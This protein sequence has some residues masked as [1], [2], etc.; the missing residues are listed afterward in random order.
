MLILILYFILILLLLSLLF[1]DNFIQ[2]ILVL[3]FI[4]VCC[5][6]LYTRTHAID[7]AF[8]EAAIGAGISTALTLIIVHLTKSYKP[9]YY[10]KKS[11]KKFIRLLKISAKT[12]IF[13]ILATIF[14]YSISYIPLFGQIGNPVHNELS[15][16]YIQNSY[17]KFDIPNI[18]TMILGSFRGF[19]TMGETIVVFLAAL[20]VYLVLKSPFY[21]VEEQEIL[22]KEEEDEISSNYSDFAF[23]SHIILPDIELIKRTS[24]NEAIKSDIVL[25][26]TLFLLIPIIFIFGS[27]VQFYGDYGPGGGFQ[28]GVILS[29]IYILITIL[30]GYKSASAFLPTSLLIKLLSIGCFIYITTG[31]ITLILGGKFLDYYVFGSNFNHAYH[32]GLLSIE[33]GVCITVFASMCIMVGQF[34]S[35]LKISTTSYKSDKDIIKENT[36]QVV[37]K[38]KRNKKNNYNLK[39]K[40]Y[41]K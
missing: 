2:I 37:K 28:A 14:I 25:Y 4:S 24:K 1:I 17:N 11:S 40:T 12:L 15:D 3:G 33:L 23:K 27:Y 32:Y 13:L 22:S 30:L 5:V 10:T 7:V 6:L 16:Y 38:D 21:I 39:R 9:Y 35:L 20:G 31:I 18:V 26:S 8:T 29:S 19:D 34:Y 36:N 41:G